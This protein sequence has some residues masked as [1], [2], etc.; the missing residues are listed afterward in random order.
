MIDQQAKAQLFFS[1]HYGD[2]PLLLPN[3]WDVGSAKLFAYLGFDALAT[4]SAGHAATLGRLD[5][6]VSREEALHHAAAI[7]AATDLPVSS[8]FEKGFAD[9]KSGESGKVILNWS[10]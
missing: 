6:R 5:G 7:V 10:A 2:E 9:M 3:P 8:D 4:T 1:L